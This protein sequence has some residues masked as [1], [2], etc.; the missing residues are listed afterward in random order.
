[1]RLADLGTR[2]GGPAGRS[3]QHSPCRDTCA[4]TAYSPLV[5]EGLRGLGTT[6]DGLGGLPETPPGR[7][8]LAGESTAPEAAWAVGS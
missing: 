8:V 2:S 4:I 1:M 5:A 6:R 3:G 7:E